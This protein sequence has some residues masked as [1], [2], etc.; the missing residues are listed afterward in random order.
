MLT[1][2]PDDLGLI[3]RVREELRDLTDQQVKTL[4]LATFGGMTDS[5]VR[6][7]NERLDRMRDLVRLLGE[8]EKASQPPTATEEIAT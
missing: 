8:L 3:R 2:S 4:K 1:D 5:E 6:E 7:S